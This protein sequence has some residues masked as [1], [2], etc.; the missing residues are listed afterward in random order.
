MRTFLKLYQ[1][2]FE[3]DD[4]CRPLKY[5]RTRSS[6]RRAFTLLASVCS[7]WYYTLTG[8]PDSLTGQSVR[9]KLKKLIEREYFNMFVNCSR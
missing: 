4:D 8:W 1:T 2:D 5:G 6:E 9:Y 3:I 7:S